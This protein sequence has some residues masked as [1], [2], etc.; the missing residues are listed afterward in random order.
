MA[1]A[2]LRKELECSVCLSDYTDPV[3][4]KCGHNFCRV[5]IDRVLETQEEAGGYSCPECREEFQEQP[6]LIRNLKSVLK[7]RNIMENL[8]FHHSNEEEIGI[9]CTYCIHLSV[10]ALKHCLLCEASLCERQLSIHSKSPEHVLTDPSTALEDR[11]CSEHKK[12][13][14]YYCTKD[15]AC[16]CVSCFAIGSHKGHPME[17]FEE[18][19]FQRREDI[20]RQIRGLQEH[21]TT[22]DA[23]SVAENRSVTSLFGD[24]KGQLGDLEKEVLSEMPQQTVQALLSMSDLMR[25]LET[26]KDELSRKLRHMCVTPL[27]LLQEPETNDWCDLEEVDSED[28]EKLE[29]QLRDG[30]NL[31]ITDNDK[32]ASWLPNQQRPTPER[33]QPCPQVLNSQSF[34]SGRHYW[35][36]EVGRSQYWRTGM[37][38]SRE[39]SPSCLGNNNKSWFLDRTSN[40]CS[41]IHDNE[42]MRL[43]D[44]FSMDGV[45]I[46]L[47]YEAGKISFYELDILSQHLYTFT[48]SFTEPLYAGVNV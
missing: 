31:K 34:S 38:Y 6:A 35:E 11:K 15:S 28:P 7:L 10:P 1:S 4:L 17:S 8:L 43:P 29:K 2:D 36:V 14:E 30:G 45:R 12:M 13:L 39:R 48:A 22:V 46:Y 5:C 44:S 32:T 26:K 3:T 18:K 47:D 9:L 24:L 27:T 42:V 19:M 37:S 20:K 25:Q 40:Q 41:V 16:V 33:F 21:R 23:K